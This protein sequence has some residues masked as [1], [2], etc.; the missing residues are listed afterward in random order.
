[1]RDRFHTLAV[2]AVLYALG[3][4]M[5]L[6]SPVS[7][8]QAPVGEA[9][10]LDGFED[11]SSWQVFS[12]TQVGGAIRAAD[13]V[14]GRA[15]CL[16]YDF[17]GVSGY[18]G[19]RRSL[20]MDYPPDYAFDFQ[21][22]GDS[23]DNNLEFKLV[24]GSGDN[25]WWVQRANYKFPKAWTQ[26]R[27]RKRH[28]SKAW[29]PSPETELKHSASLEFT[30]ASGSGGKGSVCFDQL[31]F[32]ALQPDDGSPLVVRAIDPAQRL[33]ADG[34]LDS[35][36]R[37]KYGKSSIV[38]D[39][40][41]VREF[42]G[43]RV[44][45]EAEPPVHHPPGLDIIK[46]PWTEYSV[47]LSDDGRNWRSQAKQVTNGGTDWISMP[48]SEARFIRIAPEQGRANEFGLS[49]IQVQPLAFSE[50]DNSVLQAV[51][52]ASPPGW[53]P[54]AVS[55][56]QAYW[57]IF[58]VDGG[59]D[60]GLISEDGAIELGKGG[61]TIEPF[62]LLD[63]KLVTWAD[64]ESSQKLADGYLPIP[65]VEWRHPRF[66]LEI[67]ASATHADHTLI[68]AVRYVLRNR[69][70]KSIDLSLVLSVRPLQVN[71]PSQFLNTRGGSTAVNLVQAR[72]DAMH[73]GPDATDF[74]DRQARWVLVPNVP[75]SDSF[76]TASPLGEIPEWLALPPITDTPGQI[77]IFDIHGRASG[78][79]IFRIH[80]QPGEAKT[81]SWTRQL[82]STVPT[83]IRS[84]DELAAEW[85][86]KLDAVQF[87]VPAQGQRMIETLRYALAT[88]L[89][90]RTGPRLQPGTRSYARAWIRDG[91][92]IDEAL[93]RLGR[94]D[95][96]REFV[97]WYAPYQFKDGKV[98]CCVDDR[99]S[100]PVP[101]ND[102]HGELIYA[103]AEV[104]RYTKDRAWLE[105]QWPH[106]A[107][108]V[109]YMDQLR[110]SERTPTWRTK[111]PAFFGLMPASISHEGY[112]AKAMHSY[113]DDFWALRGYKDAV[114]IAQWLGKTEEATRIAA[115]RD[116]FSDDLRNSL[117]LVT[118]SKS[119]DF[120]PGSA[121][122]GDFDPTSTTIALAPADA[123]ALLPSGLLLK[124][125]ERYW[126]ESQ[127]RANGT[128][129]WK[130]YT[131]YEL[132]TI[133][134]FVRLGLPERAH[135]ML[136]FFFKGQQPAGWR[137]WAEVVS[138]TPRKPF[139][140]GDLPHA[141][142]ASD[143]VRSVLDLFAYERG[144][145]LVLAGGLPLDWLE[146][147]GVAIDGLRTPY[148]TLGYTLSRE[149]NR[150]RQELRGDAAPPGGFVW[151]LPH[152][153]LR[154]SR[155]DGK[156]ATA[157]HD[158][159]EITHAPAIV[160]VDLE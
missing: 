24:D 46:L 63:G 71:P 136:D 72:R 57:T 80:L 149:G 115:A 74:D 94:E 67:T 20:P 105:K 59:Y 124:S 123:A 48:E 31:R 127:A 4:A 33:A 102:S 9:R 159:L 87:K 143:Y 32:T 65:I 120:I 145:R 99:G 62:V 42:G 12:S 92:M 25:V 66:D 134:T 91:A 10:V 112:S 53:W 154:D 73:I 107:G 144:E 70:E 141:W 108:A 132:R 114:R 60:Q 97:D 55:G 119:L 39:L 137:Q 30:L 43:L 7:H 54:R 101:E 58:G 36:W 86:R 110:E 69:T 34:R 45:W 61:P 96:A 151:A 37:G 76:A 1:M 23:P 68:P 22:R 2:R 95:V 15:V 14:V 135:A 44:D 41:R 125:F 79:W 82:T 6:A 139:F 122:L 158:E 128:R 148:G 106:V 100:D 64:V 160:E 51:A 121:E 50:S 47:A 130:D 155:I 49:E 89:I 85:H 56:N 13:G 81:I 52:A 146:G 16:D 8:A 35:A 17:H 109:A 117:E 38:L 118:S 77:G 138:S 129:A 157:E 75:A 78:A 126:N 11:P 104:Y 19:I 116:Q 152:R 3:V 133:G 27:Y 153:R 90:S 84:L 29:G 5:L 150:L 142:V 103:I 147:E 28:V 98:P 83:G 156:H 93:L 113:W 131:P 140:L 111:N 18:V 88:M 21:L 40:G 26:V